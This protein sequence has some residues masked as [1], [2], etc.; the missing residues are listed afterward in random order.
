MPPMIKNGYNKAL[1]LLQFHLTFSRITV[2]VYTTV[3]SNIINIDKGTRAH[4]IQTL[5]TNLNV[6]WFDDIFINFE[7]SQH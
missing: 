6:S 2:Q 1:L 3:S 7:F 4:S 5:L